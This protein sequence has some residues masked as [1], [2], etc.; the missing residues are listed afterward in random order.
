MIII[1]IMIIITTTANMIIS[2]R[3]NT[4]LSRC[5]ESKTETTAVS[6]IRPWKRYYMT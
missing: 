3:S 4:Y 2:K 6:G 5:D 1:I